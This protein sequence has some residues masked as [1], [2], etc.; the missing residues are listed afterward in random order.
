FQWVPDKNQ[1]GLRTISIKV[2]DTSSAYSVQTFN[3]TV[4][5][6]TLP[7]Y[8]IGAPVSNDNALVLNWTRTS[9]T[10]IVYY[11]I[12]AA[13][14]D[15]GVNSIDVSKPLDTVPATVNTATL[16]NKLKTGV[17]QIVTVLPVD[18]NGITADINDGGFVI[19]KPLA[20]N[21]CLVE[22]KIDFINGFKA[23]GD[24]IKVESFLVRGKKTD[25]SALVFEYKKSGDT[26]W[27]TMAVTYGAKTGNPLKAVKNIIEGELKIDWN[28]ANL[29]AG[30]YL[31]R[32]VGTDKNNIIEPNPVA[33]TIHITKNPQTSDYYSYKENGASV[34]SQTIFAGLAGENK[35]SVFT[36]SENPVDNSDL[37]SGVKVFVPGDFADTG[38]NQKIVLTIMTPEIIEN[39]NS[40]ITDPFG[41][42]I[43]NSN[44]LVIDTK[45]FTTSVSL[46]SLI[47]Q[48]Q[49]SKLN[50]PAVILMDYPDKDNDGWLDNVNT[51][52]PVREEWLTV[53]Y[54]ENISENWKIFNTKNFKF[55][56][57]KN[58][59]SITTEHFT[60]FALFTVAE[61]MNMNNSTENVV[62]YPNPYIPNGSDPKQG[63][64]YSQSDASSGVVFEGVNDGT[65]IEIFTIRGKRVWSITVSN[66]ASIN[67]KCRW[68][69]K[70]DSGED[71]ASG[72][73]LY[74]INKNGNKKTG[75]LAIVR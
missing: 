23:A 18:K 48:G 29:A 47:S 45:P 33:I 63:K 64:P 13:A 38:N 50:K 51:P 4:E 44:I 40:S 52:V 57:E 42:K 8:N 71:V 69:A 55:D 56:Y 36:E 46:S 74:V 24:F 14:Y 34:V 12:Y 59:V 75:K 6:R 41:E 67:W 16:S 35:I 21:N 2:S 73:Y 66:S 1:T 60:M 31:V 39:I 9:D 32:T 10:D 11:Y 65:K 28:I 30:S 26:K 3:V 27:E 70:N 22:S 37:V 17:E 49:E 20:D 72:W 25:L 5:P 54:R 61:A 7:L 62:V 15:S 53:W 19:V 43:I 58:F 68:N